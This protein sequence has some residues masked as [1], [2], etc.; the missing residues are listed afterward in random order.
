MSALRERHLRAL[1]KEVGFEYARL[2][3]PASLSDAMRDPRFAR[4]RSVPIDL[5]WLPV[6]AA[7]MLLALRFRPDLRMGAK[8]GATARY[9][10]IER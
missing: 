1:A 10:H 3:G 7:L 5:Y 2:A 8:K 4:P 9:R 6:V